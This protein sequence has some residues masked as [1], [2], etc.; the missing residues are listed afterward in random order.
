[1]N[2]ILGAT[3]QVGSAITDFLLENKLP[4]KAVIRDQEKAE[5]LKEKGA[6]V[7]IAD[8]FDLKALKNAVK[9]GEVIFVITPETI[10]TDDILGDTKRILENYRKAI[11][12]SEIKSIIGLSSGGAHYE[13]YERHT[14]SLLMS[15]MLEHE[16]VS[17]PL[18]QVFV[19]PS[20]YYSNWL[21]SIDMVKE[22]DVLPSFFPSDLKIDMNSPIEVAEFISDIIIKGIDKS[23]V[24]ELV[25]PEKY[26]S[27]DVA[28]NMA[29]VLGREV[30]VQEIPQEEWFPTMES[31][32]F[33]KNA[34]E[35]FIKM[36]ELVT[37]GNAKLERKG[38]NPIRLSTTFEKYLKQTL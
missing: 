6:E 1:M 33:S 16:F 31:I 17:L 8:Y 4:V 26:S 28:N 19:R 21:M 35:N 23:E 32:G 22:K 18:N 34:A 12:G 2:I 30:K 20:Y 37:E 7:A 14:G 15:N 27:R 11:K 29:K 13:K 38:K 5:I 3:G 10:K 9:E 24:I 25:G 36:T